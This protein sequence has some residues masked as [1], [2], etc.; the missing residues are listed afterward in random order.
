MYLNHA[1]RL[2]NNLCTTL[3]KGLREIQSCVEM[4]TNNTIYCNVHYI[5][6]EFKPYI[7]LNLNQRFFRMI[8][9]FRE[10]IL[11]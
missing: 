5:L 2:K 8:K 10:G 11:V 7:Q 4:M 6:H 3:F 1:A 9:L